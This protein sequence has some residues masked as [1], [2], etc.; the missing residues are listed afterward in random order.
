MPEVEPEREH[1][2]DW[3][4][5]EDG[6]WCWTEGLFVADWIEENCAFTNARWAGRPFALIPWQRM[7]LAELFEIDQETGLRVY[8]R[9]LA[10]LP[11]KS[12]K[13]EIAAAVA[14]YLAD[15]E[16]DGEPRAKVI[17]AAAAEDQ[18][19]FVFGAARAMVEF[20][21]RC[22]QGDEYRYLVATDAVC[23]VHEDTWCLEPAPLHE[24]FAYRESRSN[25][26]LVSKLDRHCLVQRVTS[27]GNTKHGGNIH[28][29]I[30]DELHAWP[31][32]QHDELYAALTTGSGARLQP[33]QI[34]IT[35]AGADLDKSRCGLLFLV[36]RRIERGEIPHGGFLFR[37]WGAPDYQCPKCGRYIVWDG[38]PNPYCADHPG[39]EL[40]RT[41]IDDP[42]IWRRSSPSFGYIVREDFYELE[43]TTM[44]E[45]EF[46]R[47]YLNQW[48]TVGEIP[49]LRPGTFE[50]LKLPAIV[51]LEAGPPSYVG[52]DMST[53]ND[54]T[55]VN[56]GQVW[57]GAE[58]P[59]GIHDA[60]DPP[61]LFVRARIW[62]RP[63]GDRDW[64]VDEQQV[65]DY[66]LELN[67][68][69]APVWSNVFDPWGSKGPQQQLQK[70]GLN[71][72]EIWVSGARRA[73][74]TVTLTSVINRGL[75]HWDDSSSPSFA[76]HVASASTQPMSGG[77]E[78]YYLVK[79][80]PGVRID[81]AM[82]MV[83]IEYGIIWAK[84]PE[85]AELD[86]KFY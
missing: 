17:V 3:V 34:A 24:R 61:C 15:P 46:R 79:S 29:L 11:R 58:R 44:T 52:I 85:D 49:W 12:G 84:T 16:G 13:S 25:Q 35:T 78:G 59:C 86:I 60:S 71:V 26:F 50:A 21:R 40:E 20:D 2:L 27:K 18:A 19:D 36:G 47:L 55:A 62:E 83:H 41:P 75:V 31:I 4:Q 9:A 39:V 69:F 74:A 82:S 8:R 76:R 22:W 5:L 7:W 30:L 38:E 57:E 43:L 42:E 81:A 67:R 70:Q 66:L 80:Q 1:R 6:R 51:E 65:V 48:I 28:G 14:L 32:G 33:L 45:A 10:G 77:Q 63:P 72:A 73:Q 37:W 53:R 54:A 56:L 68:D 64:Q 23:P